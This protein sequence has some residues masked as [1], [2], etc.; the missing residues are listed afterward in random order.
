[1]SDEIQELLGDQRERLRTYYKIDSKEGGLIHFV[2]NPPQ[3]YVLSKI[4]DE[5]GK[6][7][8]RII[9]LKARQEG[10]STL[11]GLIALDSMLFNDYYAAAL[12]ADTAAH[13]NEI[14]KTK[15]KT[16]YTKLPRFMK[17]GNKLKVNKVTQIE[18][19]NG[20][21]MIVSSSI[22][23]GTAQ[24]LH[25]SEYG[26][27]SLK[28]PIHA[29]EIRDGALQA[30]GEKE[31][32][33]VIESTGKGETGIFYDMVM[34]VLEN[35]RSGH[36]QLRT[37]WRLVFLP[38][39]WLP[40]YQVS[41]EELGRVKL[42]TKVSNYFLELADKH[43]ISLTANQKAWYQKKYE[44]IGWQIYS[45]YPSYADEAFKQ[46]IEGAYFYDQMMRA[47]KED[48]I[49]KGLGHVYGVPVDT[50][51]DIGRGDY[52][53]IILT[54]FIYGYVHVIDF[55]EG[56]GREFGDYIFELNEKKKKYNYMYGEFVGPH[57]LQRSEVFDGV[58]YAARAQREFG[59]EFRVVPKVSEKSISIDAARAFFVRCK[60]DS[61]KCRLLLTH[62][63]S[64]CKKREATGRWS[65]R[66]R[67]DEHS[68]A[69]DAFQTLAMGYGI[70]T[71]KE[72]EPKRVVA[73]SW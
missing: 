32:V 9:I 52:T 2:P 40:A 11:L 68:H 13:G 20:S 29:E 53:S 28:D 23:S 73:K 7:Y 33:V 56:C 63:R 34:S 12:I 39:H 60:F 72:V 17:F 65:D 66:P 21:S 3:E 41:D 61:D 16:P 10:I 43:N 55:L 67:H 69:A 1:M 49:M 59:I 36:P 14:F 24:F 22:R 15:V 19:E 71:A 6:L 25:V 30:V 37:D 18:L 57:D 48:R 8:P 50:W 70:L 62:L 64:Y 31:G 42:T 51:W 38:W 47:A 44:E 5:N 35:E 58:S 46:V 45:E 27:I 54:Q 4:Y 26:I